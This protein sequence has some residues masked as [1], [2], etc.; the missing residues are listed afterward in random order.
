MPGNVGK[1][2]WPFLTLYLVST[3]ILTHKLC[4]PVKTWSANTKL[5]GNGCFELCQSPL[6][7]STWTSRS[8]GRLLQDWLQSIAVYLS[9]HGCSTALDFYCQHHSLILHFKHFYYF[10]MIE[11][12]YFIYEEKKKKNDVPFIILQLSARDLMAFR[13]ETALCLI[14]NIISNT[15]L[16]TRIGLHGQVPL[17]GLLGYK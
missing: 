12:G 8:H 9:L 13:M 2:D 1:S 14:Y 17:L 6:R 5:R 10:L 3:Q 16:R 11:L 15:Q 4:A 7:S